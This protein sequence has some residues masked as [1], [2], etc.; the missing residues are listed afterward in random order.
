MSQ[1]DLRHL[2]EDVVTLRLEVERLK[3]IVAEE[4]ELSDWAKKELTKAR[5]VP[6]HKLIDSD[7][8]RRRI[9]RRCSR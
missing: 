4:Y 1:T 8:V 5:R 3:N 6:R 9:L 7:V 2:Q